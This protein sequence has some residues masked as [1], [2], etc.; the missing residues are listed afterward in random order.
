MADLPV[1]I[2]LQ[3]PGVSVEGLEPLFVASLRYFETTGQFAAAVVRGVGAALP[4][5]L[6]AAAVSAPAGRQFI[7]A[8][9]GPRESWLLCSDAAAFADLKETIAAPD[10]CLVDQT[11][12]QCA[13]RLRGARVSDLVLRLGSSASIPSA[14]E[15]RSS[16]V[17]ELHVL[18]LCIQ[19]GELIMMV[20]RVYLTHLLDWIGK[21]LADF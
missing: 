19:T 10:G 18:T 5:P 8:W 9:R 16:R 12:G 21:T 2:A 4:R 3:A 7:L 14:G 20:E 15:A 11:G 17:A 1:P 6:A 13:L